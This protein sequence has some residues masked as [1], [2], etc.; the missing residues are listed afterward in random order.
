VIS[1][2]LAWT[3]LLPYGS[4]NNESFSMFTH[5]RNLLQF[6]FGQSMGLTD[7]A[8]SHDSSAHPYV[9][10]HDGNLPRLFVYLLMRL[11]LTRVEWQMAL[12]AILVGSATIYFCFTFFSRAA[13]D[14][15]AFL[16]CAVLTTDYLSFLQWEVNSLRVWH[17]LFFFACLLCVQAFGGGHARRV[18]ALWF[19]TCAA[20]FYFEA[21]F[22]VFTVATCLCYA[23]FIYWQRRGLV[24]RL[25]LIAGIGATVAIGGLI[26]QSVAYLGWAIAWHDL[27]LTFLNR[28]F[29][30]QSGVEGVAQR[31]LQWFMQHHIVYWRDNPDTR[32]YL[33]ITTFLRTFGKFG[34]LVD[35]PYLIL[36]MA[37]VTMA[38]LL[39]RLVGPRVI[40]DLRAGIRSRVS[41]SASRAWLVVAFLCITAGFEVAHLLLYSTD[42]APLWRGAIEGY[43]HFLLIPLGLL[44]TVVIGVLVIL[45]PGQPLGGGPGDRSVWGAFRYLVAAFGGY[46]FVYIMSPGYLSQGYLVRYVPL[47]VFIVD[48]WIAL[49]FY[50]LI[51][52]V[53]GGTS[54]TSGTTRS[55]VYALT[56]GRGQLTE[57]TSQ[58]MRVLSILLLMFATAYWGRVQTVYMMTVPLND[59]AFMPQLAQPPYRGTTFI[60]DVYAAPVAYFTGT[61]AYADDLVYENL[62][63]ERGGNVVQLI[64][65]DK[66]WEAD[67]E[68]NPRYLR[69]QYYL[70]ARTPTLYTAASLVSLRQGER[71][72]QC[73]SEILV[74]NAHEGV[75]PFHNTIVAKDESPWD[76]W[77]IVKLDPSIRFAFVEPGDPTQPTAPDLAQARRLAQGI[78]SYYMA[79]GCYPR[80]SARSFGA[81]PEG[82]AAYIGGGWPHTQMYG[83]YDRDW[84]WATSGAP[85][86]FVGVVP[87]SVWKTAP[88]GFVFVV[89]GHPSKIC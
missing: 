33:H 54:A 11:G 41:V 14:L 86:Y 17:G 72:S 25:G 28:N 58:L 29:Y 15:F 1:G 3:H 77:A 67:R 61:W 60:S 9:Y 69:P 5:A 89:H 43:F 42:F 56:G 50:M 27:Q 66:L 24:Y 6:G 59:Y 88:R 18:G 85:A 16:V 12:L 45:N 22:A 78:N 40:H 8:Y 64:S 53:L 80:A 83:T 38:W 49:F 32:G 57:S 20:L 76:M 19:L 55:A 46:V 81:I 37:I 70:C 52:I 87:Y 44:G 63:M 26:A 75:G 34:L 82:L 13:G 21:V 79:H 7:E 47:V 48:V 74:H 4:D 68:T 39:R 73:S 51:A 84:H 62:Y 2:L 30:M 71:L 31:T 23:L 35:T 10:T 65:G 36:L